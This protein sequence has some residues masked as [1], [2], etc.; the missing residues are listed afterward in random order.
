MI[1]FTRHHEHILAGNFDQ[2]NSGI[3]IWSENPGKHW[4]ICKPKSQN[5]VFFLGQVRPIIIMMEPGDRPAGHIKVIGYLH[6]TKFI[7]IECQ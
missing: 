4:I 6:N 5:P 2:N 1:E 3:P 7:P